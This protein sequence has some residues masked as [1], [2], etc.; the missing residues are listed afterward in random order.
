MEAV[1]SRR[2]PTALPGCGTRI[3]AKSVAF[4]PDGRRAVSGGSD[5]VPRL[6][7]LPTVVLPSLAEKLPVAAKPVRQEG[8]TG[9]VT[10]A[11]FSPDGLRI[12]T[13]GQDGTVRMWDVET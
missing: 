3:R 11:V 9:P 6:W 7:D 2:A 1:C 12:L 10:A 13:G 4:A 8:H 5:R